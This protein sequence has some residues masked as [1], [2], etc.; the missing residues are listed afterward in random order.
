[1]TLRDMKEQLMDLASL[2]PLTKHLEGTEFIRVREKNHNG[3]FGRIFRDDKKSLKQNN[4]KDRSTVVVQIL[5]E[6]ETLTKDQFVLWLCRRD[7]E[8]N[9]Y[10]DKREIVFSGKKLE[11]LQL[12]ALETFGHEEVMQD[13]KPEDISIAKHEPH[14]YRWLYI[15]PNETITEKNKKGKTGKTFKLSEI[16]LIRNPILLKD[17]DEIGVRVKADDVEGKDDW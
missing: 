8:T 10:R 12:A 17:G 14:N 1:M 9:T 2:H 16:D 4:I 5:T 6:P 3:F 7:C 11:H 13:V 15:D